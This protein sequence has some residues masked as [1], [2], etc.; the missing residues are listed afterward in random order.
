MAEELTPEAP[1][2]WVLPATPG[3]FDLSSC[4]EVQQLVED[5][6]YLGE[7]INEPTLFVIYDLV[8]PVV[9]GWKEAAEAVWTKA[10]DLR[11]HKEIP[12]EDPIFAE[13]AD[14]LELANFYMDVLEEVRYESLDYQR[15]WIVKYIMRPLFFG[16]HW[17]VFFDEESGEIER[18]A[19]Y[20]MP[21]RIANRLDYQVNDFRTAAD[22]LFTD[23]WIDNFT[24]LWASPL[25]QSLEANFGP[26]EKY[27]RLYEDEVKP[28]MNNLKEIGSAAVEAT[29][30]A[31]KTA[32]SIVK[33]P[34]G[35]AL[36]LGVVIYLVNTFGRRR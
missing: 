32:W 3:G 35:T 14:M 24:D 31:A 4:L 26:A 21:Q 7:E 34:V 30:A 18:G 15:E 25:A 6:L 36:G 12:F 33:N 13:I 22:I 28:V 2:P 10:H 23:S 19:Y 11:V 27:E 9:W 8:Y 17:N 1:G 20:C 5:F 16:L 29:G